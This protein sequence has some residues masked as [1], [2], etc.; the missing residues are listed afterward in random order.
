MRDDEVSSVLFKGVKISNTDYQEILDTINT[1]IL[2]KQ[3][4]YICITDVGNVV[5]AVRDAQLQ[6]AI[7]ESMISIPDGMPLVW[8]ARMIGCR[9]IERVT[10]VNLMRRLFAEKDGI[11]HYLLGDTDETLKKVIH[12]AMRINPQ[13]SITGHSPPF[14]VFSDDDNDCILAKIRYADPDIIW[15]CFGGGKQDKWMR[16]NITKIRKGIMVGV[17]AAFK[18]LTG[19]IKAP[20]EIF[21]KMGLQWFFRTVQSV[22]KDPKTG[23]RF[24]MER[25]IKKFPLFIVNFPFEVIKHRKKITSQSHLKS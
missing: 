19:D 13:I 7:N 16:Q 11:K 20:P 14:R 10:G 8:Y 4:G 17:G 3:R 21:Q 23:F 12:Q 15:V 5:S 25:Q 9:K 18:W 24:L 1:A 6:V 22:A 2:N